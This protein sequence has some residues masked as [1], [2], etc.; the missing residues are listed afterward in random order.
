MPAPGILDYW[1]LDIPARRLIVH[2]DPRNG[3]YQSITA[4][5][6]PE[7]VA[8]LAAPDQEF[9]VAEAFPG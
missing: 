8:P 5:K 4:Y 7:A 2:R 6:M 3:L 9:R 1:V